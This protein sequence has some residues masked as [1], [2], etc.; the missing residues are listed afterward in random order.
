MM[1]V[2]P[3]FCEGVSTNFDKPMELDETDAKW[4]FLRK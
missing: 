4:N 2:K 1:Q 3:S